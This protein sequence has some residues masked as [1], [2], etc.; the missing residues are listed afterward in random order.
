MISTSINRILLITTFCFSTL[1]NAQHSINQLTSPYQGNVLVASFDEAQLKEH[2]LQQ[3][4]VK[5]SG[6]LAITHLDEAKQLLSKNQ[7]Y[8]SQFGY[9]HLQ[10]HEYFSAVFDKNKIN[11][12]LQAMQQ[13]VWGDTRPT[14]L[15]WLVNNNTIVSDNQMKLEDDAELS[16][17]VQ[18]N[19]QQRGI[20][21][22]F[23]LMD[24]D[25]SLALSVSDIKGRFYDQVNA[26]SLR[27]QQ[28][29]FV[30]AQLQSLSEERWKLTWQLLQFNS[31]TKRT[32]ALL[33]EQFVGSKPEVMAQMINALA[34]F[35]ASQF[36]ILENQGDKFTQTV[37]INGINS[38]AHISQ[39]NTILK[40]MLAISSYHIVTAQQDQVTIKVK[41]K[42]GLNS[43]KN[44]LRVEPHLELASAPIKTPAIIEDNVLQT[45]SGDE[46]LL[47]APE[48]TQPLYFNWR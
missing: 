25:D 23:P 30:G 19:E 33:N 31:E 1:V 22:Q 41:L 36:A 24:L 45:N 35:Y 6:N 12:A 46:S 21:V 9:R 13:P 29:Y 28:D 43:F 11:Q 48:Q 37:H 16:T 14:T 3:V 18:H 4:L 7:Q 5:V 20:R 26:A 38:L 34:D 42:G 15:I 27:Y 10:G 32:S 39:L 44:T 2:A 40:N 17:A 47:P 8:L